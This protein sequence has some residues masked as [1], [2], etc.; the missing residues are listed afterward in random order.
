M[1]LASTTPPVLLDKRGRPRAVATYP[2]FNAGNKPRSKGRKYPPHPFKI[3]EIALL[4]QG[5]VTFS[6]HA[7]RP[8]RISGQR[9]RAAIVVMWR[10]GLRVQ[11]M[12][13]LHEHDLDF[14]RRMITVR[15]GKGD[16][17]RVVGMDE[18][19][20]TEL[21]SWLE[22][23]KQ[24]PPGPVFCTILKDSAGG[25]WDQS[26][27]RR[28]MRRAADKAGL[29]RRCNPHNLRHTMATDL[30]REEFDIYSIGTQL[31]HARIDVTALYLRSLG[32]DDVI[33]PITK[34]PMPTMPIDIQLKMANAD[35]EA[36]RDLVGVA[37]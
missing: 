33:I 31:G 1:S 30:W 35:S 7:G 5:C 11:E 32:A 6:K 36:W 28:C 13:D 8:V 22:I 27:V 16:K 3:Q 12:L 19:G 20:W 25:P 18:F 10:S 2:G 4:L 14:E 34:R 23:R 21:A 37:A 24:F 15:S 26:D 29:H 17:R 9:I